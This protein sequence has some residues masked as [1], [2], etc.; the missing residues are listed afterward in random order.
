MVLWIALPVVV[1]LVV[2]AL[3][4]QEALHV[5][6]ECSSAKRTLQE[7][8]VHILPQ[9]RIVLIMAMV[10]LLQVMMAPSVGSTMGQVQTM[11]TEKLEAG[12]CWYHVKMQVCVLSSHQTM[13]LVVEREKSSRRMEQVCLYRRRQH[14]EGD[15][16]TYG[17]RRLP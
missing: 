8:S 14:L 16:S 12:I 5:P 6:A 2:H 13:S 4:C 9:Q 1:D 10:L 3:A 17:P 11:E 7:L 15:D